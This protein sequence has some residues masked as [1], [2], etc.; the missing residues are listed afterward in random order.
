VD[1]KESSDDF[2]DM[3]QK[4]DS[5]GWKK[6]FVDLRQN[7]PLGVPLPDSGKSIDLLR[8]NESVTSA[9]LSSVLR[10]PNKKLVL[11]IG[12]NMIIA[13]SRNKIS[14]MIHKGG[15]PIMDELAEELVDEIFKWKLNQ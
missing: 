11:P 1:S 8:Q 6:V 12:H 15:R 14:N 3:C 7:I 13:F 5:L 4:L 10:F 2:L 9:K